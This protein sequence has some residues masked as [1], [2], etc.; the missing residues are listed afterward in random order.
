MNRM[1]REKKNPVN[2]KVGTFP[3]NRRKTETGEVSFTDIS[4]A[5]GVPQNNLSIVLT[6]G[7]LRQPANGRNERDR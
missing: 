2:R 6:F 7:H 1:E 5:S 4:R 3:V